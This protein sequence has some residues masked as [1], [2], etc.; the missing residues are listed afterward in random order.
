MKWIKQARGTREGL[1]INPAGFTST[2]VAILHSLLN[3]D[4]PLIEVHISPLFTRDAFRHLS[5]V[6]KAATAE[7]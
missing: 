4:G 7:I 1:L 6:S 5:C 2:S 3:C